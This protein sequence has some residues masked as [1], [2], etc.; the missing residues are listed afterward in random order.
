[1]RSKE[2]TQD[3]SHKNFK[4]EMKKIDL[5]MEKNTNQE[6]L[7]TIP[8]FSQKPSF[9][10]IMSKK[11]NLGEENF[12][13]SQ[14]NKVNKSAL[15]LFSKYQKDTSN[16]DHLNSF[17]SIFKRDHEEIKGIQRVFRKSMI[18]LFLSVASFALLAFLSINLFNASF[19]TILLSI[20]VFV[21]STN[22]FYIIVGDKSYIW[23]NLIL[24]FFIIIGVH[25]FLKLGFSINTIATDIIII[26][27][28]YLSYIELEKVQLG[29]R[30]FTIGQITRESTAV[31]SL[32]V[33]IILSLGL[34]NS[35]IYN[36]LEKTF[37]ESVLNN[38][39]I[40]NKYVIGQKKGDTS[41]NTIFGISAKNP[42]TGKEIT[43]SQFLTEHFRNNKDLVADSEISDIRD[44][45]IVQNG[46]ENCA[47]DIAIQRVKDTRLDEWKTI[48]YPNVKF[49]LDTPLTEENFN[50]VVKQ[51]YKNQVCVL[52]KGDK[53][54]TNK[55]LPSLT[56]DSEV[57]TST[58]AKIS[59]ALTKD[60]N[61]SNGLLKYVSIERIN[62]IPLIIT[63]F[64]F[65]ILN[66]IKPI[67]VY[68]SI[69]IVWIVWQ[70]LRLFGF[71]KI[72][73]ETVEA[74]VV[75]I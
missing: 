37:S 52:E 26:F 68:L 72:E 2:N 49:T 20:L 53:C 56:S 23:L 44:R 5:S 70:I 22:I 17:S 42:A 24:Q 71:V 55:E 45:C 40:F 43:F 21:L 4:L 32:T 14:K 15:V 7:T 51:Y 38:S 74:E 11:S 13:E 41:L 19:F 62:L 18:F 58:K 8:K 59:D 34:F 36:G 27:L 25:S 46:R 10:N 9:P 29:S 61:V 47:G 73:I 69:S 39:S 75:S 33:S 48:A 60:I 16:N 54:D 57:A 67:F 30:L 28:S 35:M 1:M 63:L 31:L 50:I 65:I 12:F 64:F 3:E 66:I 6:E